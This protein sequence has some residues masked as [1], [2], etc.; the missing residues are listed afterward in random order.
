MP[1]IEMAKIKPHPRNGFFFDDM[2]GDKWRDF[3]ES[4]SHR[5]TRYWL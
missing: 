1:M 4:V 5:L 3:K 2:S